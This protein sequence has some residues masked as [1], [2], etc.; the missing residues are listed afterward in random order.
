MGYG[1]TLGAALLAA[2]GLAGAAHAT[3]FTDENAWRAAVSNVYALETWDTTAAGS[4]VGAL[5]SL[6]IRFLPLDDGTQPTVQDYS[7]TGGVV[8]SGPHNLLNDR[9][10]SLPARGPLNMVPLD[11]DNLVFGIG[12]WNVGGDDQLR[13]SFFDANDNLIESVISAPSFG[14]FGIVNSLG[15]ARAEIDFVG[16]NGYAP[17]DDL[18]TA[19]RGTFI[20]PDGVPEPASWALMISGFG[21]AGAA[22]RRR[23]TL[24]A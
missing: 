7:F 5:P 16:G 6:G 4:D 2:G 23:R 8:K 17:T 24:L 19:T 20:P 21:L 13:L 9:D 10:Q 15:A 18:Q 3:A 14:F 12:L 1:K 22:L 11:P